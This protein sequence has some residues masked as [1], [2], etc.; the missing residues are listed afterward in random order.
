MYDFTWAS[1]KVRRNWELVASRTSEARPSRFPLVRERREQHTHVIAHVFVEVADLVGVGVLHQVHGARVGERGD[2]DVHPVDAELGELEVAEQ[3]LTL[4]RDVLLVERE[5]PAVHARE[6]PRDPQRAGS[7]R[8]GLAHP[9]DS[10]VAAEAAVDAAD[11][12]DVAVE[13]LVALLELAAAR[14]DLVHLVPLRRASSLRGAGQVQRAD[15]LFAGP[16]GIGVPACPEQR[17]G[18][19]GCGRLLPA[20]LDDVALREARAVEAV[21]HLLHGA[22]E[23]GGGREDVCDVQAAGA[24]AAGMGLAQHTAHDLL[25]THPRSPV[26][27]R[28]EHVGEGAV[29]PLG[30]CLDGDDEAYRAV[31]G[32][33][34]AAADLVDVAGAHGH[35][36]GRYARLDEAGAQQLVGLRAGGVAPLGL[37]EHDRADVAACPALVGLGDRLQPAL[38]HDGVLD[39]GALVGSAVHHHGELH[40]L[41][42]LELARGG[43]GDHVGP[44]RVGRRGELQHEAGV[45]VPEHVDGEPAA[46]VMALVHHHE[47]VGACERRD[48]RGVVGAV[49]VEGGA[50]GALE[51]REA[52]ERGVLRV[53]AP[54]LFVLERVVGEH[55]HREAVAHGVRVEATAG[56][57]VFL[58][59]HLDAPREVAVER[60]AQEVVGVPQVP[61]RLGENFPARHEPHHD[62]VVGGQGVEDAS[63]R[64]RAYER[65]AAARGDL[66]AHARHAGEVV[67]VR[68]DA[69]LSGSEPGGAEEHA[70]GGR[71]VADHRVGARV[72]ADL[73]QNVALVGFEL[74]G[75]ILAIWDGICLNTTP[76]A[77]SW[78]VE[79]MHRFA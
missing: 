66:G 15:G 46:G 44:P 35:L 13:A 39:Y 65:L 37:E 57:A 77:S 76:A 51:L 74:H 36:L 54:A 43:L 52:G 61:E 21:D 14:H 72:A 55:E 69:A 60:L 11:R 34:V 18:G 73:P 47:R 49:D 79:R 67:V 78:P 12:A 8:D 17:L 5:Q 33:E 29:P 20:L 71:R 27:H 25:H 63:D 56:E 24:R 53:G 32:H 10:G 2:V 75:Y 48:E 4:E 50:A 70:V 26:R 31:A 58:R 38:E 41:L 7:A 30:E 9:V 62:L 3:V 16:F 40:H 42:A 19:D 23:V 22:V 45:E 28:R 59:E 1:P 6:E 64:R 68:S